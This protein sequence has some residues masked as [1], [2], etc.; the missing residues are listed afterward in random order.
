LKA[1]LAIDQEDILMRSIHPYS[2]YFTRDLKAA[3]FTDIRSISST[4]CQRPIDSSLRV[5]YSGRGF[6]HLSMRQDADQTRDFFAVF[7]CILEIFVGPELVLILSTT[8]DIGVLI[9]VI[10]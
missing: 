8:H 4:S 6:S 10:G 5:P 3:M 1:Y 7:L 2:I 9:K